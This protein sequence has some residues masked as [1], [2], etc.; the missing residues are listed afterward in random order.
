M[1]SEK[2]PLTRDASGSGFR[3]TEPHRFRSAAQ[4]TDP[5]HR[6]SWYIEAPHSRSGIEISANASSRECKDEILARARIISS[7]W[8]SP[9]LRRIEL[10]CMWSASNVGYFTYRPSCRINGR[11]HCLERCANQ[12]FDIATSCARRKS[13]VNFDE[14]LSSEELKRIVLMVKPILT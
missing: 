5:D 6:P 13:H 1:Q 9:W 3:S 2:R 4:P 14:C 12:C 8:Y 11:F 7:K 10:P